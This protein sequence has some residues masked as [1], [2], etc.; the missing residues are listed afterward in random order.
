MLPELLCSVR[1]SVFDP[2]LT[3]GHKYI[4]RIPFISISSGTRRTLNNRS[5]PNTRPVR[6]AVHAVITHSPANC[7]A[8]I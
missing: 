4:F 5:N 1:K 2:C 8:N 3:F 6:A 7:H